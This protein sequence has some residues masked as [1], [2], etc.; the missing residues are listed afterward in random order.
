M[1][2]SGSPTAAESRLGGLAPA[3]KKPHI[4]GFR[5]WLPMTRLATV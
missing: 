1:I 5:I 4:A 2:I 3:G